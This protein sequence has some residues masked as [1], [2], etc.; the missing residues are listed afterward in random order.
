MTGDGLVCVAHVITRLDVG[1]AQETAI[2]ICA[3]L[4]RDRFRPVLLV[5]PDSGSGGSLRVTAEAAGVDVRTIATLHGPVRPWSDAAALRDLAAEFASLGAAI[6]QTHS[7]KAGVVGRIGARRAKVPHVVHT[8][9]GWSFNDSQPAPVAAAYQAIERSMAKRCDALVVVTGAD[10]ELG[11]RHRI[12]RP[13]QYVT[14]RSGIPLAADAPQPLEREE[15]RAQQGW[16]DDVVIVMSVGRL[17]AQKDPVALVQALAVARGRAPG[18]RLVLVGS[19]SLEAEVRSVAVD[20]GVADS[21]TLLGLRHD[22][23]DLLAAADVFALSSR[24]EGLPRAALEATRAGLP[25]VATDTGGIREV[26]VDG[27]TGRLVPIGDVVALGEALADLAVHPEGAKR[28]AAAAGERL[29][30]FTE[31][32]MVADTEALYERLVHCP[33]ATDTEPTEP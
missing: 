9:H 12:G 7:S 23:P 15:V 11:L 28:L 31:A 20:R 30:E 4:D 25:V 10:R 1:G 5:G 8:V 21:V 18:L 33:S 6:V 17:E 24:W 26:I 14:I 29:P 32:R 22:V 16:G 3:G 19:G 27:E 13:D 2:R